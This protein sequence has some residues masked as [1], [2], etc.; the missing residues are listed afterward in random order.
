M[1]DPNAPARRRRLLRRAAPLLAAS[2]AAVLSLPAACRAQDAPSAP[3]AGA[4]RA[5]TDAEGPRLA[6]AGDPL[7]RE[8]AK[9][10][11]PFNPDA[12]LPFGPGPDALLDRLAFVAADPARK[13]SL[14]RI[15]VAGQPFA[16]ALRIDTEKTG[17]EWMTHLQVKNTAAIKK[18]DVVYVT[19]WARDLVGGDF[20][21]VYMYW[22]SDQNRS[23]A[24]PDSWERQHLHFIAPRDWAPGEL[25]L[26]LTF[27]AKRQ[28]ADIAALAVVNLGPGVDPG[29]LPHKAL[30]L[31]YPGREP[32]APWRK[33]AAARIERYRKADLAVK[34]VD[35]QGRPVTGAAVAANMTRH[36][37]VFGAG[38]PLGM[39]PGQNVKPYND[40]FQRTAGAPQADKDRI[41]KEFLRLFNATTAPSVWAY[42]YGAD[43]RYTRDDILAGA[44]WYKQHGIVQENAQT[45]YPSPEF[46][47]AEANKLLKKETAAQ[48]S[49]ALQAWVK[50]AA[51]TFAPY[52]A[53][54][55]IAN[56]L[57][58]RPQYTNVLG[59]ESVPDWFK[60]TRQAAPDKL[61]MIN[62]GYSLGSGPAIETQDRGDAFP[63]TDGLQYYFDLIS[64]LLKKGA[65]LDYI[66][67]QNHTGLGAPGPEVVLKTMTTFAQA[68]D[69]PIEVT[70]FEITLQDGKDAGQRRY[71]AD[72]FRDF[73]TAVFSHP[74]AR[75]VI[76]QDFWQP[77]AWQYE[78]ASCFFN[79]DW[80]MNPHGKEYERLVLGEWWTR[81][82]G[83]TDA[84]GAYR[85]RGF[86]G[87]YEITVT[88]PGGRTKTVKAKLPN[89][90]AAVT[91]TL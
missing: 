80:S 57:E 29:R 19:F 7:Y 75:G 65:P 22:A 32:G 21:Q 16:R 4:G 49:Q 91:V 30:R 83:K 39:L 87:D 54:Y 72:Y 79:K 31:T 66:G 14:S 45:I 78:G 77:G 62:G 12:R 17:Q 26:L 40:D 55:Q 82:A 13:A 46:T 50:E 42:W 43:S 27:G 90:G 59:V 44:R 24:F 60:W 35:A 70:E 71:Q 85:T 38:I 15:S 73:L 36:A 41:Q 88:A 64:W 69:R 2:A 89:E 23:T 81:A 20:G 11:A 18:G 48:F 5:F 61:V 51:E 74:A 47:S 8:L 68:F 34:V 9:E 25:N 58:G 10:L 63:T 84:K 67:F 52:T 28:I 3:P 37:F 53:S 33:A 6:D 76:L 56:E 1:Q 86:H